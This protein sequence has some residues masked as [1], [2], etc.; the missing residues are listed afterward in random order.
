MQAARTIKIRRKD[1]L[2]SARLPGL[3]HNFDR[4]FFY[5]K[6][7]KNARREKMKNKI[8]GWITWSIIWTLI[9]V[10]NAESIGDCLH[11]HGILLYPGA[12]LSGLIFTAIFCKMFSTQSCG[13]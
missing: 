2:Y 12:V 5:G 7:A 11:Y 1:T 9:F 3:V 8:Y 10:G 13:C 4:P 6:M